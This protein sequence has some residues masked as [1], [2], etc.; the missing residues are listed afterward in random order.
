MAD[1]DDP[2]PASD[3]PTPSGAA[4]ATGLGRAAPLL[5]GL[6]G[7]ANL[8]FV[9]YLVALFTGRGGRITAMWEA[10][11]MYGELLRGEF[12]TVYTVLCGLWV[13]GHVAFGLSLW[14]APAATD[15]PAAPADRQASG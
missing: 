15:P 3:P 9:F 13:A 7:L 11:L 5:F 1:G 2:D 12:A 14:I 4:G 6:G 10:V 8:I